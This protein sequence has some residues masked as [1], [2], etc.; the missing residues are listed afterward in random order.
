MMASSSPKLNG[1]VE[2]AKHT[3]TKEFCNLIESD[4]A[5]AERDRNLMSWGQTYDTVRPHW[6]LG[7]LTPMKFLGQSKTTRRETAMCH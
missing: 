7:Y 3:H 1:H 4:F 5:I 2:S 6:D